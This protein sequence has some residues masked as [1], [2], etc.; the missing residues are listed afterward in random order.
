MVSG[1]RTLRKK[2]KVDIDVVLR[3]PGVWKRPEEL[4]RQLPEPYRLD[5]QR[6]CLVL[7]D[8]STL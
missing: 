2:E 3:I 7:P 1:I 4:E 5:E 8:G 6:Q